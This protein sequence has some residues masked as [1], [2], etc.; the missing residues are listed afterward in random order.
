MAKVRTPRGAW[1]D[2]DD[3]NNQVKDGVP[4][5]GLH[6]SAAGYSLLGRRFVRQAKAI[7]EGRKPAAN[8][9]PE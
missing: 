5:N 6:Y 1:V 9:R 7:I 2:C 3:L 4:I 8:G